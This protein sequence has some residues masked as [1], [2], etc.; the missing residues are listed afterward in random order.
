MTEMTADEI[1]TK[2]T[3]IIASLEGKL[4]PVES[5][6]CN[7]LLARKRLYDGNVPGGTGIGELSKRAAAAHEHLVRVVEAYRE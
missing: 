4:K 6:Y 3:T 7:W 2:A 1:E 5:A